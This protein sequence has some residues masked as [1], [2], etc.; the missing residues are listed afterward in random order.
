[1]RIIGGTAAGL[2]LKTPKG[3]EVRPTPDLVRQAVFNSLGGRVAGARVLELFGGTGALSL[4]CLSRGATHAHCVERSA[5]HARFIAQN[6]ELTGLPRERLQ[7]RMQDAFTAIPQL[8]AAGAQ[9]NL[10]LA[11]PPFGEKNVG[12]RSTSLAQRLLDDE[13]LPGLLA[14]GG[15]FVLGHAKRDALT[16]PPRWEEAKVLKHGDSIMRFLRPCA[17]AAA[18]LLCNRPLPIAAQNA[19]AAAFPTAPAL[20]RLVDS[21]VAGTLAQ[22]ADRKLQSNQLAVTLV[23]LR[24]PQRPAQGGFRGDAPLYPASVIKLFYLVAAQRWLEDGRL[25]DTAELRRALRDMIVDSSNEAT[26]YVVDLLTGTTSGPELPPAELAQWFDQRN[27][28]NRYFA[29]LGY[30]NINA[31]RKPWCEGP[32]GREMQSLKTQTPGRNMLTTDATARLLAGIVAG[33]AVNAARSAQMLA[34]MTRDPAKRIEP[35]PEPDQNVDFTAS[36]LPAGAKL[37]SKAGWTSEVRHDAAY[38]ELP[39]G[40]KFVLVT[41]TMGH[42]KEREIIP[43]VARRIVVGMQ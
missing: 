29:A 4:E 11:D 41:F 21:A 33:Q 12:R 43:A 2:I 23:D 42:S 28:V 5:R 13:R 15:L 37:W 8:A 3:Y 35:G 6:F 10:V 26:H 16:V 7:V 30:T 39:G 19:T 1:M 20:Q 40:A 18:L 25:T 17:L 27:A 38:V 36:G 31:N 24:E 9:F 14:A 22:F 32:Y 34:L